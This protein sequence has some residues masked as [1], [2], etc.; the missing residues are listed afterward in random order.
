MSNLGSN[1]VGYQCLI[2]DSLIHQD[3]NGLFQ[4]NE[5]L[6]LDIYLDF[7]TYSFNH[8]YPRHPKDIKKQITSNSFKEIFEKCKIISIALEP[9]VC[10]GIEN[11]LDILSVLNQHWL[12][13][14][15]LD[16]FD[17]TKM[18]LEKL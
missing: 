12:M 11:C 3:V 18:F 8:I 16:I 17:E 1:L 9:E 7:F 15:K 10:G 2:G 4:K 14:N 13:P 5:N 6:I